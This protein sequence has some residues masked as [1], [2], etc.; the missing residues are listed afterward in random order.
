MEFL[1]E[2]NRFYQLD[3]EQKLV[4]E[5]RFDT[6]KDNQV[7]VIEH[8]FTRPDFRGQGIA[9]ELVK[10]VVDF[11]IENHQQVQPLCSYAKKEFIKN[12]DY[13]KIWYNH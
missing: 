11:A 6:I 8:T 10:K 7:L 2:K 1:E 9:A 13:Q 4:A 5:I 12:K 3:D